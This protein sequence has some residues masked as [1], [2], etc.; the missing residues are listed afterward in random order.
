MEWGQDTLRI[1]FAHQ[2]N[3]QEGTKKRDP[4]HVYANPLDPAVCPILS[5]AL[6]LATYP[7]SSKDNE[8]CLFPG[9]SQY[10]RFAKYF[11]K[12]LI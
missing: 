2:K 10:K 4:R 9:K 3:D 1:Y 12:L 8:T 6:Y 7:P 5:L 11:E